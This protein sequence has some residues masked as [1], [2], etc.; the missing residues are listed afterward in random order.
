MGFHTDLR[1]WSRFSTQY[2]QAT[3]KGRD[4]PPAHERPVGEGTPVG[5]P[6]TNSRPKLVSMTGTEAGASGD[7]GRA[8]GG[9]RL[10]APATLGNERRQDS[11]RHVHHHAGRLP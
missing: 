4:L 2:T 3:G 10:Q 7:S 9:D 1:S 11:E 8:S 6:V 5:Q